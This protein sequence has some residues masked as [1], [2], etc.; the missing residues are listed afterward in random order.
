MMVQDSDIFFMFC[1]SCGHAIY[2]LTS[3]VHELG[4]SIILLV[5]V[6][7]RFLICRS[8]LSI[9]LCMNYIIHE[10]YYCFGV[11]LGFGL[12]YY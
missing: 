3:P 5:L 12:S 11:D 7:L 10:E 6:Q 2:M 1:D 9:T 4:F 8:L